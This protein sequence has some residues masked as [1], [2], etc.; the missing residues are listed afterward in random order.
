MF[1]RVDRF[2]FLFCVFAVCASFFVCTSIFERLPHTEDEISYLWQARVF[3]SGKLSIQSPPHAGDMFIPF[4]IDYHGRRFS[5][6]PPGWPLI[7]SLGVRFGLEA[8]VNPLLAGISVWLTY[9][10]GKRLISEKVGLIAAG[11]TVTSPFF[12]LNSGSFLSSPLSLALTGVF[13]LAWLESFPPSVSASTHYY[14]MLAG[15]SLGWLALTRPLTALGVA[16]PFGIHGMILLLRGD[17]SIRRRVLLIGFLA[18]IIASLYLVWQYVMTGDPFLNPYTLWWKFD[19]IGFGKGYGISLEGHSLSAAMKNSS[20]MLNNAKRDI[21]G[22]GN[23]S[24]IFLPFGVWALRRKKASWSISTV[25]VSLVACYMLYWAYVTRFGPRYYYEGLYSITLISAA[26][27]NWLVGKNKVRRGLTV[28]LM[29]ILVG[30]N[31]FIYL[32]GRL[33]SARAI[34]GITRAQLTPFQT[35]QAQSLTPALVLVSLSEKTVYGNLFGDWPQY[36]GLLELQN[37]DLTSPFI[38]A[39]MRGEAKNTALKN[40]YPNRRV[41]YYYSDNYGKLYDAP[42][43]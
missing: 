24:W 37:P 30:Y 22:W 14:A 40:D 18:M 6:Y 11:L 12:L 25:F 8:W 16:L 20:I 32:P 38:F 7:F 19:K 26:G 43:K 3:A 9:L 34:Y 10:L 35:S 27:I 23:Y 28:L 2:A 13:A 36:G 4:V 41:I 29:V 15:L 31:L 5:K 21:F 17:Q 1:S 33:D 42:R 39:V